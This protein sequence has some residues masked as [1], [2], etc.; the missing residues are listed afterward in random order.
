MPIDIGRSEGSIWWCRSS[1]ALR[2][3]IAHGKI[4]SSISPIRWYWSRRI[5]RCIGALGW[6]ILVITDSQVGSSIAP[7]RWCWLR[8][9]RR[10]RSD[11]LS[12]EILVSLRCKNSSSGT[13]HA[14]LWLPLLWCCGAPSASRCGCSSSGRLW[15][16]RLNLSR[17]VPS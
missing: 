4:R 1:W 9:W 14:L 8:R 10:W 15:L 2:F 13:T 12:W 7:R 16:V 6:D 5:K 17:V 3:A 11:T